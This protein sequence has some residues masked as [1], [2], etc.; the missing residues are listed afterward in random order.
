[1]T[2]AGIITAWVLFR[3]F[4]GQAF[5]FFPFALIGAL[6]PAVLS[7]GIQL[8]RAWWRPLGPL[9]KLDDPPR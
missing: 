1:M 7:V 5:T 3:I 2:G 6:G 4:L 9:P 8:L